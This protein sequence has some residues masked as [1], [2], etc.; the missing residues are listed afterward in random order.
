MANIINK[1]ITRNPYFNDGKWITGA[2]FKGFMLHSVGCSQ[3]NPLVFIKNWDNS[4]FTYAGING[5]IGEDASYITAPCLETPGKVK[6]MPHAGKAAGNNGY[7]GFEMCEPSTITYTT[8]ASFKINNKAAAIAF[9]KKVYHNAVE[10]FAELCKFHGKNP[11]T[12]GVIISHNE[13]GKSGVASG[14]VDPEHLW[15][16]LGLP[17]TMNGFRQDVYNVMN[18]ISA[19]IYRVR[20]TWEDSKS[21][22]GAYKDIESAKDLAD[23]NPGYKVFDKEGT[24]VYAGINEED[25]DMTQEK[26]NEMMANYRKELQDNDSGNWSK[27]AR[28]W[29]TDSGMIAGTGSTI[30]GETNYA[31]ADFLTREQAATLFYRFAKMMGQI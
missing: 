26:F 18:K 19:E 29:A 7:I 15:K 16:G 14:H 20:K 31:W 8:G 23:K 4:S 11:L 13:G 10:L 1:Y 2:A 3:P 27:E 22:I 28:K 17:Y 12:P 21:Q 5:F 9:T 6:R 30:N 25:E 24:M